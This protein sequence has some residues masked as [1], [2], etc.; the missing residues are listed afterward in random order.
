MLPLM[1]AV[2]DAFASAAVSVFAN[3]KGDREYATRLRLASPA[4]VQ[5]CILQAC[6]V[7]FRVGYP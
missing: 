1:Q 2:G 6:M 5:L 7:L 4:T 3:V